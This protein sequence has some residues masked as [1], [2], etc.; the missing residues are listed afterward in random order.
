M[1]AVGWVTCEPSVGGTVRS[2]GSA[3]SGVDL[4]DA[5]LDRLSFKGGWCPGGTGLVARPAGVGCR[6]PGQDRQLCAESDGEQ[7][8]AKPDMLRG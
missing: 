6:P 3:G 4:A 5:G 8:D 2:A 1:G 7:L